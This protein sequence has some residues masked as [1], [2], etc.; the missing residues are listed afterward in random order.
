M[1]IAVITYQNRFYRG[2]NDFYPLFKWDN[3]IKAAGL[4]FKFYP[5]FDKV[6][7]DSDVIIIDYRYLVA[8]GIS[9]DSNRSFIIH[10]IQKL[11][12]K[13]NKIILFDTGDGTGS[14]CFWIIEHIDLCLKK[15]ILK[16][17]KLYCG[18]A[19]TASFMKW[20]PDAIIEDVFKD[21]HSYIGCPENQ[22]H[23]IQKGWNI[24]YVDYRNLPLGRFYPSAII[25]ESIV[26]GPS[27]LKPNTNRNIS[28]SFRGTNHTIPH[29]HY[30][31]S[32]IIQVL[33][34]LKRNDNSI[35]DGGKVN[36]KKYLNELA[37]S[38]GIISPFGWGEICYRDF[39]A[40]IFG[41]LLIKPDMKHIDTFPNLFSDNETYIPFKWDVSDF[42]EKLI[43][44]K[45]N[46]SKYIE[47]AKHGQQQYKQ[48]KDNFELF[49]NHLI[50]VLKFPVQA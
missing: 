43:D 16:D 34:K 35:I 30:Q 29:Y 10:N 27:F 36:R 6:N 38:T 42:E 22:L 44:I 49:H 17:K 8:L 20:V 25:P 48:V 5:T 37:N 21:D 26:S 28:I 4:Y 1:K 9:T 33:S 15:Q 2:F 13:T 31:R 45:T 19:Y 47:V 32:R 12:S 40:F 50:A 46:I 41:C 24:A 3:A 7:A 23:K 11:R 14:D 18:N 39:E